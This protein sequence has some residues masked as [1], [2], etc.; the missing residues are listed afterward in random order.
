MDRE[1]L[2][3]IWAG[4]VT[5]WDDQ[6]IKDLNPAIAT[7]L[8]SADIMIGYDEDSALSIV[9]VLKRSL[10]SFS[11]EFKAGLAAANRTFANM[12]PALA[13]RAQLAGSTPA[14]RLS[15]LNVP[16]N[17]TV[18]YIHSRWLILMIAR[19]LTTMLSL[20]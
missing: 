11:A 16:F 20:S 12:A 4:N 14:A 7:K 9:E 19:R 13:G 3:R 10:E 1:T 2:G 5:R 15:W 17:S 6:R 8:P 18:A